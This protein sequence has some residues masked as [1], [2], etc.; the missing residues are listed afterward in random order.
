MQHTLDQVRNCNVFV[1]EEDEY[2]DDDNNEPRDPATVLK[3]QRYATRLY[4][5][6]LVCK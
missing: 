6:F 2:G 5:I 3:H 4:L 1:H